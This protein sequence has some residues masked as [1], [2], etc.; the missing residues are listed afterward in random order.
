MNSKKIFHANGITRLSWRLLIPLGTL[1]G[2][3]FPAHSYSQEATETE[4][5]KQDEIVVTATRTP[6]TLNDVPVET[7]V[8]T[9][10]EIEKTSAQ[11]AMDV[12]KEVPGITIANHDD[13]F[14]TYTWRAALRGLSFNN[15]YGLV[16]IDG[17][18]VMGSGQSGGMGEYGIGLNN[19][20]I[21]MVERIEV[22]KG[23]GSA[24]YGSDAAAGVINVITRR[25]PDK[26]TG[27][28]G[29]GYGWYE[30]KRER[31]DGSTEEADG[32]RNMAQA[33][34]GYGDRISENMG[35]I[36]SYSYESGDDIRADPLQ[37]DRHS[38]IG[39]FDAQ[40]TENVSIFS[41]LELSDYDKTDNRDEESYRVSLG[42]EYQ[43]TDKHL[44]TLKGYTYNWDFSHGAPGGAYGFKNGDVGY[45]QIEGQYTWFITENNTLTG[46]IEL[47]EQGID[48]TI[49]NADNSLISVDE[50]ISTT[51]LFL[52]DELKLWRRLTLVGGGRYDDHS[53]FGEEFNPKFSAMFELS[54]STK[55]RGSIGRSFKSP[56]IRQMYYDMPYRHGD[57]YVQ[58]NRE[59]KPE[60]AIGYS[61]GVEQLLLEDRIT[62]NLGYFRNDVDDMVVTVDTGD[63]Y[64]GLPLKTY[65]NIEEAFTQGF[66]FMLNSNLFNSFDLALSYTFTDTENKESGKKI[67]YVPEHYFSLRPS[68]KYQP[69]GLGASGGISYIGRQFTNSENTSEIDAHTLVSVKIYKK[70]SENCKLTFE[71]DDLFDSKNNTANRYYTGRTFM[72]KLDLTF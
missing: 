40:V 47:Q 55:L 5:S 49:L 41:K 1:L 25:I 53:V 70:I 56:T 30:V 7:V 15:G 20:P 67:T 61:L 4:I 29:T 12:L 48:Y 19:I 33:Y 60:K 9:S 45:N 14:G 35:Y 65:E 69:W 18:R 71:A 37:S 27:W 63:I 17:Q 13:V 24:L 66:E 32:D 44:F 57:Y 51:S 72:V 42:G 64:D 23:P 54:D 22:V 26:A 8:I 68:Y 52:Q 36:L 11:N 59:L 58:S 3:V 46:G 31:S 28:A 39:K 2:T 16:L 50:S 34:V 21:S 43:F 10:D 38:V 62:V 6:H